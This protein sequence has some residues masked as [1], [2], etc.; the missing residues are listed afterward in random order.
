VPCYILGPLRSS[1][2]HRVP[3]FINNSVLNFL[4]RPHVVVDGTNFPMLRLLING[5]ECYKCTSKH[6]RIIWHAQERGKQFGKK[7]QVKL[8]YDLRTF[9]FCAYQIFLYHLQKIICF[10]L[11]ICFKSR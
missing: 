9:L 11:R 1:D 10:N 6:C 7:Q 4:Q 2:I 8:L 3:E 5:N